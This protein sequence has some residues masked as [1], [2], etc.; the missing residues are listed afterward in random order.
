M[1]LAA[2]HLFARLA[3]TENMTVTAAELGLP[4][5]T[6]SRSLARL[7]RELGRPLFARH[8]RRLKLNAHGRAFLPHARGAL[9]GIEAGRAAL[10]ALDDPHHGTIRLGFLHSLGAWLV[11]PL[12][13]GFRA[14]APEVEFRLHQSAATDL[15]EMLMSDDLDAVLTIVDETRPAGT[16][17]QPLIREEL[18]IASTGDHPVLAHRDAEGGLALGD[19]ARHPF[20]RLSARHQMQRLVDRLFAQAGVSPATAFEGSDLATLRGLAAAGLGLAILP[21][22]DDARTARGPAS[23]TAAIVQTRISGADAHRDIGLATRQASAPT[24]ALQLFREFLGTSP[25]VVAHPG[26]LTG[27]ASGPG[28][29]EGDEA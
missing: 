22:V 15:H 11:P 5:P 12:L 19:A 9:S 2:L 13:T 29:A 28:D 25:T 27:A 1:D 18:V 8:G 4:Q 26:A 16:A 10:R 14:L 21:R 6:L 20:L 17:W 3:E 23:G 24:P 7:E